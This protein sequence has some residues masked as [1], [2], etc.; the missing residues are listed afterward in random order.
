M[1][2]LKLNQ[3]VPQERTLQSR[4]PYSHHVNN[5]VIATKEGHYLSTIKLAG[6]SFIGQSYETILRWLEEI[7]TGFKGVASENVSIHTHLVRKKVSEYPDKKFDNFFSSELDRIYSSQ[8]NG[9]DLLVNDLYITFIFRPYIGANKFF[10]NMNKLSLED[11]KELQMGFVEELEKITGIFYKMFEVKQYQPMLLGAYSEKVLDEETGYENE[12]MFCDALRFYNYLL[13][14]EDRKI[15]LR[16]TQISDYIGNQRL[17]FSNQGEFGEIRKIS[18]NSDF[19]AMLDIKEYP[20]M[21]GVGHFN[22][23]MKLPFEFILSQSFNCISKQAAKGFLKIQQKMLR[24]AKDMAE[25]Q[26]QGLYQAMDDL[27]SGRFVMGEHYLT[28]QVFGKDIKDTAKNL[29]LAYATMTDRDFVMTRCDLSLESAF[30]SILPANFQYIPR[31]A[32]I[33]SFNFWSFNSLHNYMTGKPLNNPWGSAICL[34]KTKSQSPLYFNFHSTPLHKNSTG[35]KALGHT[36][37]LGESGAGKTV[38]V[39]ILL[40]YLNDTTKQARQV[41][42]DKDQGLSIYV[43]AVNGNYYTIEKDVPTGWN[44]LQT[45][46]KDFVK[47][48]IKS[49]I[50]SDNVGIDHY[51]NEQITDAV[52]ILMKHSIEDRNLSVFSQALP[53]ILS[54]D[55]SKPTLYSRIKKWLRGEENGYLFDNDLDT[56]DLTSTKVFGFDV[57][58]YIENNEI[59]EPIMNYLLHRTNAMID[60][61][62][63]VYVFDEFWKMLEAQVFENLIKNQLKTIRKKNGICIFAT[64]EP[65]DVLSHHLAPTLVTQLATL[66]LLENKRAEEKHY[67]EGLKLTPEQFQAVLSIEENSRDFIIQQAGQINYASL[68]LE[69]NDNK[70]DDVLN[71]LSGTPDNAILVKNIKKNLAVQKLTRI[72]QSDLSTLD[73]I[74]KAKSMHWSQVKLDSSEWLPIFWK[75]LKELETINT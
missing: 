34:M 49:L 17:F 30:F 55:E 48:F 61:T 4:I 58:D 45:N 71:V 47:S 69:S 29:D 13:T 33:S 12:Y 54:D 64:Q 7:N 27:E 53:N 73:E 43:Q 31:P 62:P 38:L 46:D 6:R 24:D 16:K 66:L 9:D 57:G 8:F 36:A 65:N 50:V 56:L 3:T 23:L 20:E 42:F 19:F 11:R 2:S 70:F 28:M 75:Q 37:I 21:S 74:E 22:N 60:G 41:I 44:P 15:S 67:V 14:R 72:V 68:A 25:S 59:R 35:K 10:K 32:P 1:A 51:D 26:I 63:F 52:E 40:N 39:S 5:N 18:G